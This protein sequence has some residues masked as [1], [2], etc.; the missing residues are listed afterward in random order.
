MV[1]LEEIE[2][3]IDSTKQTGWKNKMAAVA[4]KMALDSVMSKLNKMKGLL[5]AEEAGLGKKVITDLILGQHKLTAEEHLIAVKRFG[6][7]GLEQIKGMES[8]NIAQKQ[9][10]F[11]HMGW[12]PKEVE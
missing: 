2:T 11:K 8:L 5:D 7:S 3:E 6:N 4:K 1:T 10:I 12:D 9:Y